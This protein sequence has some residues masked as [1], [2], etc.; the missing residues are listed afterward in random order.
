MKPIGILEKWNDG[1]LAK[2]SNH[3]L[4]FADRRMIPLFRYPSHHQLLKNRKEARRTGLERVA[5]QDPLSPLTPHLFSQ[6]GVFDQD[7]EPLHPLVR[8]HRIKSIQTV[9]DQIPVDSD[10]SANNGNP[11]PLILD[12]LE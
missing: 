11:H 2:T 8:R 6:R 1:M 12:N 9:L 10:G 7:G 3:S 5:L 4:S